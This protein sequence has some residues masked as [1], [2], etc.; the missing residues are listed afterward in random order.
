MINADELFKKYKEL[1][2][3]GYTA[4]N[5]AR[6]VIKPTETP[7]VDWMDG[8]ATIEIGPYTVEIKQEYD[9]DPDLSWLG[10]YSNIP[11]KDA[12]IRRNPARNE[13]RF[14]NPTVTIGEYY[15][16][17]H[18]T[19]FSKSDAWIKA[20]E[21]RERDYNRVESFCRGDWAMIGI[22]A[23]ARIGS[24]QCGTASLWGIESD[25]A[26]YID[27]IAHELSRELAAAADANRDRMIQTRAQEIIVLASTPRGT[28]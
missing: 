16:E 19:G 21:Y 3:K 6:A 2:R 12:I 24:M 26:D 22:I 25:A 7:P 13:F 20:L 18:L 1:R 23:T 15:R 10:R 27:E 9:P 28:V 4:H 14:W 8:T 17:L 5:A 11:D